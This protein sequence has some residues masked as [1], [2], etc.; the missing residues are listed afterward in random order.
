MLMADKAAR[1]ANEEALV[2]LRDA[3]V[4]LDRLPADH[5]RDRLTVEVALR[6]AF[7]LYFLGRFE[8]SVDTLRRERDRLEE[9]GDASLSGR[10]HFWLA[11]MLSRLGNPDLAQQ[12][13]RR[14]IDEANRC[15]DAATLGTAHRL[16]CLEGHWWLR[17]GMPR[18]SLC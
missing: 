2:H 10:Y 14:A 9:L 17:G 16:L 3:L 6:Q 1:Y 5:E 13:A 4:H 15:G 11:H 8:Q 12:S 18:S 7:S